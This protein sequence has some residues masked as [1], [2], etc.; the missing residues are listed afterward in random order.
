MANLVK[1]VL[2]TTQENNIKLAT[3]FSTLI[4]KIKEDIIA[5]S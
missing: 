1:E 2:P 3:A 4:S 5:N